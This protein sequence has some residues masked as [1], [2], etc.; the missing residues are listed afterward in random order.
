MRLEVKR[1]GRGL[2]DC[3]DKYWTYL[4]IMPRRILGKSP[5]APSRARSSTRKKEEPEKKPRGRSNSAAARQQE[6][7]QQVRVWFVS[8]TNARE[9]HK[10]TSHVLLHECCMHGEIL[11][12]VNG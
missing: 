10:D 3:I 7:L 12:D 6:K 1:M 5:V 4:G 2:W 11:I 9:M 8:L